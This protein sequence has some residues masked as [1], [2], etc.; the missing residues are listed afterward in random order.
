MDV[1]PTVT[2][3]PAQSRLARPRRRGRRAM[4]PGTTAVAQEL[5]RRREALN[6]TVRQA[7]ECAQV[8]AAMISEIERGRRVPSVN[9]WA[10]LRQALSIDA[11]LSVL[12]QSPA[13][14]EVVESHLVRLA[15]CLVATGGHARLAD[16]GQALGIPAAAV[17]EQLPM[18][19]PRL[20]ACGLQVLTDGL[21]ARVEP[22]TVCAAP[23][24]ALG[25]V[26][27]ERRRR[28]LSEEAVIVLS[29][30]GW[31]RESTRREIERFRGEDSE[32]LLGRLFDAD[33]VAAV[34]DDSQLGRP[35]RYRLTVAGLRSLGVASPEELREKLSPHLGALVAGGGGDSSA[36]PLEDQLAMLALVAG[37]EEVD[38]E[39]IARALQ[40]SDKE[41]AA[42]LERCIATGLLSLVPTQDAPRYQLGCAGL[43]ALGSDGVAAVRRE[44]D[45]SARTSHA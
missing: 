7:A 39:L 40:K 27:H 13:P 35:N 42:V 38:A 6:L 20:A 33:L 5:R 1:D 14:T 45:R 15:C 28:A 31:H 9:T 19:A 43:D 24:E 16:L 11:P 23:L 2:A 18:V 12:T 34:R 37:F 29:Y 3:T 4:A 30:I 26:Q 36:V 25:A 41:C 32:T 22:L 10:K 44:L 8:T 21:E 17:R